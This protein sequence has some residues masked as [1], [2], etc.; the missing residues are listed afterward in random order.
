MERKDKNADFETYV[1]MYLFLLKSITTI[2]LLVFIGIQVL[3]NLSFACFVFF[4][5]GVSMVVTI[6][7]IRELFKKGITGKDVIEAVCRILFF[8]IWLVVSPAWRLIKSFFVGI[9]E[10]EEADD[11]T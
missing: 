5:A 7:G 4:M 6:I 3:D 10:T 8:P 11:E 9:K 2:V 1:D